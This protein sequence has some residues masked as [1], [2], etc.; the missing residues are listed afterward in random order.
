M[1]IMMGKPNLGVTGLELGRPNWSYFYISL[2]E[3]SG[4]VAVVMKFQLLIIGLTLATL[5]LLI[6]ILSYSHRTL[7]LYHQ[8]TEDAIS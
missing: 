3:V 1:G 2:W 8:I 5:Y 6:L 7:V 4:N